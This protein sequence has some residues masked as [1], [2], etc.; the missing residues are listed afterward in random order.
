MVSPR[1]ES[2]SVSTSGMRPQRRRRAHRA[3][4]VAAAAQH[5]VG[6]AA[7][8]DR[9]RRAQ[10]QRGLADRAR[11]L[12]RV[13]A[14]DALDAGSGRAGSRRRG[15]ARPP[16]AGRRRT[17][18]P[19]PQPAARRPPRWP[20]RRGPPFRPA[21]ITIRGALIGLPPPAA[22]RTA[23]RCAVPPP[24]TFSSRPIEHQ[25]H[26]QRRRARGDERQRHAGQRREAEHGVDVQQ[27]LAQDQRG[28]AGGEQLRVGA[29]SRPSRCAARRTRSCRRGRAAR[30]P[31]HPELLA[32]H[33][34]DEVG[35][36]LREVEDLLDRLPRADAR[37]ARPSRS[38]SGPGRTGSRRAR[39]GPRVRGTRSGRARR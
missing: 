7:A 30:D 15:R 11:R 24:A 22:P 12:E 33:G 5:G 3:G 21:A 38:R 18:P 28:E 36:R 37:T 31:G 19:R 4:D 14:R 32:D 16:P 6:A 9:A 35:V 23:R 39:V 2:A 10:R 29:A 25:Q 13:G 34:E 1:C 26:D 8:Q 17:R 20:A 27:R